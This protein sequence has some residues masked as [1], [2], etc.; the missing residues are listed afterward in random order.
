MCAA[1][2]RSEKI[3]PGHLDRLAVVYV[4]QST[5]QQ[6][7][8]HSESTRLQYGLRQRAEGWGWPAERVEVI[9]EDLGKSGATSEGRAG[10]QRLVAEV[11][12]GHVGMILGVDMSRLAR[13]CRDWYH[14]L[15]VC[16]VFG[17]LIA[18]LDGVYDPR[19][20][21]DRL[22]LGLKGTM[23]EAELHLI[24][25]RMYE[26][27]LAKARRGELTTSLP[28]GYVRR[29]N[30]EVVFDPDE[31]AQSTVRL[32]FRTFEDQPTLGATLRTLVRQGVRLGVRVRTGEAKG[33][34]EWRRLN[35][36]TL[37]QMLTHPAYA[38]AYVYGRRQL[39]PSRHV[40]GRPATGRVWRPREEWH[41]L[42]RDRLPAYITWQRYEENVGRLRSNRQCAGEV[43]APRGGAAL[44]S[45]MLVCG[46]C[47]VRMSAHYDVHAHRHRYTCDQR[48]TNYAEAPCQSV[49]G[50]PLDAF[51]RERVLEALGP[52]GLELSLEAAA[53]LESQR[54]EVARH[55]HQ[56][57]ERAAY[58]V[59]RA[60]R[61]HRLVEPENR[62]VARQLE[63]EWEQRLLEQRRL[64]EE[65]ERHE[66]SHPRVLTE[67]EREA[68]RRV[69][70]D[71][72]ALW[73]AETTTPRDRKEIL[74]QVVERVRAEVQGAS[75]RVGL[76]IHWV[77]GVTTQH[78]MVRPVGSYE[79]MS[80]FA[81]LRARVTALHAAG[82]SCEQ[83]AERLDAEGFRPP[84][85]AH[86]FTRGVVQGLV[87]RLGLC[88]DD[89]ATSWGRVPLEPD[90]WWLP[91]LA[92]EL[93][94]PSVSLYRW[95]CRGRVRARRVG[96]VDR[97]RRIAV[98]ADAAEV[99][100]LRAL[101]VAP[102]GGRQRSHLSAPASGDRSEGGPDGPA[103]YAGAG[104]VVGQQVPQGDP[105]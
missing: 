34:L 8:E 54:E 75:E 79:Q 30:G 19:S 52:A 103:A 7:L 78:D 1:P 83:M 100:R 51:V 21:N 80:N 86:R 11:T 72:P 62:L 41:V 45:G 96:A 87:E 58:E 50:P 39:D 43:G 5:V 57:R 71:I 46:R 29:A 42:L 61:R 17:T 66:R 26:G 6:V 99:E 60:A 104:P 63:Q 59:E 93:A 36:P 35:R 24:R 15:E 3:L 102:R 28:A 9:D 12:L 13:S 31:Q 18:D 4:R 85:R 73:D 55:W 65:W 25:Q 53:Q 10:F 105:R 70:A 98:W 81:Q 40:P 64:E 90:E 22:L 67:L 89:G 84:K 20:Y 69:A 2:W 94:M 91:T 88:R 101:R 37:Q 48:V 14:L 56:R 38:G 16:A 44:L 95:V 82:A 77:G 92:R 27:R 68:I 23:S 74:R 49:A 47:G 97:P 32:I 33:E 76:Q